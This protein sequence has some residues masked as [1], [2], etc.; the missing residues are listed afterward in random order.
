[1][2]KSQVE[3]LGGIVTVNSSENNGTTFRI[4]FR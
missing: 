4:E 2:V 3:I 1:M